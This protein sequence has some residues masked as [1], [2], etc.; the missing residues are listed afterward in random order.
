MRFIYITLLCIFFNPLTVWANAEPPTREQ[1]KE[2]FQNQRKEVQN[3]KRKAEI[4]KDE[5]A[6][7]ML[8]YLDQYLEA[9]SQCFNKKESMEVD[10]CVLD[11]LKKLADKG[12]YIA[13]HEM[14]N[15][16]ENAYADPKKAMEW[17]QKALQNPNLPTVYQAEIQKDIQR[18]ESKSAKPT[19]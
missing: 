16:Y 4:L 18:L 5:A 6:V 9:Q 11:T 14:G 15:V 19:E 2:Q 1:E 12:N 13:E 8:G 3:E 10:V 7:S 17:Y